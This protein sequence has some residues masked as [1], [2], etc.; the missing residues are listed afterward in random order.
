MGV[1]HF[2]P[3]VVDQKPV[4]YRSPF[5]GEELLADLVTVAVSD[6]VGERQMVLHTPHVQVATLAER[7]HRHDGYT[8]ERAVDR[9]DDIRHRTAARHALMWARLGNLDYA[10]EPLAEPLDLPGAF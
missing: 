4:R 2:H 8:V 7:L 10:T 6:E 1:R 5:T 3:Q 9:A